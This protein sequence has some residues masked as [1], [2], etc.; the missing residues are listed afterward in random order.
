MVFSSS[1]LSTAK[2]F[3]L[4]VVIILSSSVFSA[5][6]QESVTGYEYVG[7]GFCQDASG[8]TYDFY[9][10]LGLASNAEC[11]TAC[12]GITI[13]GLRGFVFYTVGYCY[14][15][16]EDGFVTSTVPDGFGGSDALSGTGEIT[17]VLS[18][19]DFHCYKIDVSNL[20]LICQM[21]IGTLKF[22]FRLIHTR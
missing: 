11:A 6:A 13:A 12:N 3:A 18:S 7:A 5:V 15:Q 1:S 16:F 20:L 19:T 21:E 9:A 8:N 14:C 10:K 22:D 17:S 2:Q 4:S